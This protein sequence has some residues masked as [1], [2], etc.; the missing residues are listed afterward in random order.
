MNGGV[1]RIYNYGIE[2]LAFETF[3]RIRVV[4][5]GNDWVC[6]ARKRGIQQ[7][8]EF[9]DPSAILP[10]SSTGSAH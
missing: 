7:P 9:P 6:T 4:C 5:T 1:L 2:K 8:I 10:P 3:K